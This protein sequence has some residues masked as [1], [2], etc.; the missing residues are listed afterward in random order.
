MNL[1][2]QGA[3]KMLRFLVIGFEPVTEP[4]ASYRAYSCSKCPLNQQEVKRH[5]LIKRISWYVMLRV[6]KVSEFKSD[7]GHCELCGCYLPLKVW[8]PP[9]ELNTP[10]DLMVLKPSHCWL[11]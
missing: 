8:V 3:L 6:G 7:L 11:Q 5:K 2:L 10:P 1:F 9:E 4:V